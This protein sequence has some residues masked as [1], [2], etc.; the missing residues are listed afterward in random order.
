MSATNEQITAERVKA[1][2]GLAQAEARYYAAVGAVQALRHLEAL[3]L[4]PVEPVEPAK[5]EA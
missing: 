3:A 1:E 5:E 4:Q 2:A